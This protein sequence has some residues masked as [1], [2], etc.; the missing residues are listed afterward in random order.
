MCVFLSP[1]L[2]YEEEGGGGISLGKDGDG[3]EMGREEGKD[4][5]ARL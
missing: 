2:A 3:D 1:L 4:G 5:H